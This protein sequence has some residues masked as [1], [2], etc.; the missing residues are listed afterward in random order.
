MVDYNTEKDIQIYELLDGKIV[1]MAS[2]KVPHNFISGNIY[3][4]FSK[5]LK[6]KK[7]VPFGDSTDVIFEIKK[8]IVIPDFFIVCNRNIIRY[9]GIYGTPDLIVEVLSPS[10]FKYDVNYK[11]NLYEKAGVREYWIVDPR[12]KTVC[13]FIMQPDGNFDNGTFYE[14]NQKAPVFIFEGLEIDLNELFEE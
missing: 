8:D 7:C 1:M 13:A 9:N 14:C 10:T 6:G 3:N 5:Y 11:F 2:S 4:I 12:A